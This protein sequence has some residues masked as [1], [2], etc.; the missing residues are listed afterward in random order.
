MKATQILYLLLF[1]CI[2]VWI[3]TSTDLLDHIN[4]GFQNQTATIS[5]PVIPKGVE[6]ARLS[7]QA[8][9][10]SAV[11]GTLPFGPYSQMA[12]VGSYQYQDPAVLPAELK[13]I[14][15]LYEDIRS[16]LVFEG[17]S[18]ADSSDPTVQLPLTQLRADSRKLQQ[19]ISVLEANS[20]IQSSLTQQTLAD[21]QGELAF[22]QRKVRLFQTAGVI[23]AGTEGFQNMP[24]QPKTR[25]SKADLQTLQ[26]KIYAAILIL[27][28]SGTISPVTQAR[29]KVLQAMYSSISDMINK[30]DKGIWTSSNIPVFKEDIATILPKLAKTDSQLMDIFSQKQNSTLS[31]IEKQLAGLVGED[32]ASN[33]FKKLQDNGMFR[34]SVDLGYNVGGGKNNDGQIKYSTQMNLKPDGTLQSSNALRSRSNFES[35]AGSSMQMD[36][37]F[38]SKTLGMDDRADLKNTQENKSTP[39]GLDWKKRTTSICE[40]VRLRGLDPQDF[41]CI[42]EG[43]LMSPAYSWRGHAK[44]V[45]GRLASTLDPNLPVVCGCPPQNWKGWTLSVN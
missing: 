35:N 14:N 23:T 21:I 9:P 24:S 25:A 34:L 19:E 11:P 3:V 38:D 10:N 28:S 32:N 18:I 43:S 36:L 44:M 45:C 20:G 37:P 6:P 22:L 5:E 42:P 30:L 17:P 29:I 33:V 31:P 27:S 2:I 16:F 15:Q 41:G 39:S 40:Q 7:I 4:E 13:Q 1:V 12:S 26:T 8:M